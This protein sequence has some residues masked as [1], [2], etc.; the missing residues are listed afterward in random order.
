[1]NTSADVTQDWPPRRQNYCWLHS[2]V[3]VNLKSIPNMKASMK[4]CLPMN[5]LTVCCA[6]HNIYAYTRSR[7]CSSFFLI[8]S[9]RYLLFL[10]FSFLYFSIMLWLKLLA[11][12]HD[13]HYALNKNIWLDVNICEW[14]VS[15]QQ[16]TGNCVPVL[17][18][19]VFPFASTSPFRD[20]SCYGLDQ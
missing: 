9:C 18:F 8:C 10:L 12:V 4:T 13:A 14:L 6:F 5:Q 1:L 16:K 11:F 7:K 2:I 20:R 17:D 19:F 15:E 3:I